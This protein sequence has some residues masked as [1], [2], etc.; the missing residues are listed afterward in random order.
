MKED[1]WFP[2]QIM[3]FDFSV[4]NKIYSLQDGGT[5]LLKIKVEIEDN[6][7]VLIL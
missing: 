2:K 3:Q 7:N 6:E 1:P 5:V 4:L